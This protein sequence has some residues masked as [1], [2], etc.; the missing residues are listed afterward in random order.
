MWQYTSLSEH[1]SV[2]IGVFI[3]SLFTDDTVFAFLII[4]KKSKRDVNF[5][6][7]RIIHSKYI[8]LLQSRIETDK[9]LLRIVVVYMEHFRP[10]SE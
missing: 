7:S 8:Q 2:L 5:H 1:G 9:L 3:L 10:Y 4:H 6:E